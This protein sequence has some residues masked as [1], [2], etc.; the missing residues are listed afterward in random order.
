MQ[1]ATEFA[2]K[3]NRATRRRVNQP[4]DAVN[5]PTA[6]LRLDV[7]LS[8]TGISRSQWYRLI[9]AGQA[10]KP[11]RF[12]RRCSRWLALDVQTFLAARTALGGVQ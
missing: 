7:V 3:A 10:P 2:P 5:H 11:L 6:H 8:L 4:L 9:E 1:V 12:G